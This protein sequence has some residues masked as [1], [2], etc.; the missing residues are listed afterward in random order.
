M[1]A[2]TA[3]PTESRQAAMN[4]FRASG[5][6]SDPLTAYQVTLEGG[7]AEHGRELFVSHAVAQC[8]RCHTVNGRGGMAGPDLSAVAHPDR[9]VDRRCL[10]E[11]MVLP[12]AKIAKGFG[13]AHPIIG[14]SSEKA[15]LCDW[16]RSSC[17]W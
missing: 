10:L 2:L 6:L 12:N 13:R 16:L 15:G 11:S 14:G 8:I 3:S 17:G 1:D 7:N 9:N 5:D 4:E